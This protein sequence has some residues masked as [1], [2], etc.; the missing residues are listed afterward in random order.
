MPIGEL[1]FRSIGNPAVVAKGA[2]IRPPDNDA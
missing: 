2:A 1:E